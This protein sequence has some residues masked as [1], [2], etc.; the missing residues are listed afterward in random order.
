MA[1]NEMDRKRKAKL[2]AEKAAKK[3][4]VAKR[5]KEARQAKAVWRA[6]QQGQKAEARRKKIAEENRK[7][8]G[9]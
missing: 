9:N 2:A 4:E 3:A 7:K 1:D 8:N 5:R 6:Y